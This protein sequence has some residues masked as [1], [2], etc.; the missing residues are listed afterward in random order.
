MHFSQVL[1][2]RGE[3]CTLLPGPVLQLW[4]GCWWAE[5]TVLCCKWAWCETVRMH[6]HH[7]NS[8]RFSPD[9]YWGK[10]LIGN[11]SLNYK[12][13]TIFYWSHGSQ[14]W[15]IVGLPPPFTNHH[16]F[17]LSMHSFT[18]GA[19]STPSLYLLRWRL[20]GDISLP[21][22]GRKSTWGE[23]N[24]QGNET[25]AGSSLY[26]YMQLCLCL[27]SVSLYMLKYTHTWIHYGWWIV[28]R[29]V[30]SVSSCFWNSSVTRV[31]WVFFCHA[32]PIS[33][34]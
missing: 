20:Y 22:L 16:I 5:T 2:A 17:Y 26:T 11:R 3:Q 30:K 32:H 27:W 15:N 25:E 4:G 18:F 13:P 7:K 8:T 23:R 34:I 29:P 6:K 24:V 31:S 14:N 9:W 10:T 21:F 28:F 12:H 1:S 33:L 19:I